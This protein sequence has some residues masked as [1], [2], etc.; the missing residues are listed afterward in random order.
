MLSSLTAILRCHINTRI[1][2]RRLI[3][4]L[5]F[6]N[7]LTT[8]RQQQNVKFEDFPVNDKYKFL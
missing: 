3:E 7:A 1:C 6:S 2:T 8:G 5:N 4:Q